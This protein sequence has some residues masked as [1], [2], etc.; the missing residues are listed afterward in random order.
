MVVIFS[1]L[2]HR[3]QLDL[4][5]I[6]EYIQLPT[7]TLMTE[8]HSHQDISMF[9]DYKYTTYKLIYH[10]SYSIIKHTVTMH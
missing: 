7:M 8:N 10:E 1:H 4:F 3:L 2:G 9:A 5:Q 6:L